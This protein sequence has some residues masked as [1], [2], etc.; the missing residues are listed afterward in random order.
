MPQPLP[1]FNNDVDPLLPSGS[2]FPI[3]P[4]LYKWDEYQTYDLLHWSKVSPH[5]NIS[6]PKNFAIQNT[7]STLEN[8][9]INGDLKDTGDFYRDNYNLP[10]L[11]D[12]FTP[13]D[14]PWC[15]DYATKLF[16]LVKFCSGTDYYKRGAISYA[17][18]SDYYNPIPFDFGI[19]NKSI[20]FTD[21]TLPSSVSINLN[22]P[23]TPQPEKI[24]ITWMEREKFQRDDLPDNFIFQ[25]LPEFCKRYQII[26][27][28]SSA[29]QVN[30]NANINRVLLCSVV[31]TCTTLS[32]TFPVIDIFNDNK[33]LLYFYLDDLITLIFNHIVA[34]FPHLHKVTD[35][36]TFQEVLSVEATN[37]EIFQGGK[38]YSKNIFTTAATYKNKPAYYY[39]ASLI[40]A[41]NNYWNNG[42]IKSDLG[43]PIT[44]DNR[45]NI[46][47]LKPHQVGYYGIR[48]N[49]LDSSTNASQ[50]NIS[51]QFNNS[52]IANYSEW[53]LEKG[54]IGG[55]LNY[56]KLHSEATNN[57]FVFNI[58]KFTF[59]ALIKDDIY[60]RTINTDGYTVTKDEKIFIDTIDARNLYNFS[61]SETI[62]YTLT[63]RFYN[64]E[65]DYIWKGKQVNGFNS[66]QI[67]AQDYV[68]LLDN[69]KYKLF[70]GELIN[71]MP[72]SI[73]VK[74]THAEI[75]KLK[76]VLG[77]EEHNYETTG[78]NR[79][80]NLWYF[81]QR[82]AKVL[83]ISV[84]PKTR[85][86]VSVRQRG[87]I[88][89]GS[90]VPQGWNFAQ[91]GE[92]KGGRHQKGTSGGIPQGIRNG[93]V[94]ESTPNKITKNKFTGK[95]E[96]E[97]GDYVLVENIPQMIEELRDQFDKALGMQAAEL[98]IYLIPMAVAKYSFMR[99]CTNY[100]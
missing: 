8:Q 24:I 42:T 67:S 73:R 5:L 82:M 7:R 31:I 21:Y 38:A 37:G 92:N 1:W 77:S 15:E 41:N 33:A 45:E 95:L 12:R 30:W 19:E 49:S 52:G 69:S 17:P 44:Y 65:N 29:Q 70:N 99:V 85:N 90:I 75:F 80:T 55:M 13:W 9:Y 87:K 56:K 63:Q 100:S 83:G 18:L 51:M 16:E 47:M 27:T 57:P 97:E 34:N 76:N 39:S 93:L 72:D 25:E 60:D 88:K 79:P 26:E 61:D 32:L 14:Y 84:D 22:I 81:V 10:L 20:N 94:L 36:I 6:L 78:G 54:T 71:T 53:E 64:G 68:G 98:I 2:T 66:L 58:Y 48:P 50:H 11:M 23:A 28:K 86:I 40:Y 59:Q 62:S 89:K 35:T 4:Y 43:K 3:K 96:I 91:W 46:Y 74:E